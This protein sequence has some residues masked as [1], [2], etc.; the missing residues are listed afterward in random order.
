MFLWEGHVR[1]RSRVLM[2]AGD[3]VELTRSNKIAIQATSQMAADKEASAIYL[4]Y[5]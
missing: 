1:V 4:E 2:F 3:H 5:T